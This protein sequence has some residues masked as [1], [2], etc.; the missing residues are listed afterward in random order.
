MFIQQ[1]SY[2]PTTI[3]I[4]RTVLKITSH[5]DYKFVCEKEEPVMTIKNIKKID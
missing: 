5:L 3:H 2:V 1:N 4:Y